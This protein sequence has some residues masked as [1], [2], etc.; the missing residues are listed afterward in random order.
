MQDT[1]SLP[2]GVGTRSFKSEGIRDKQ[3]RSCFGGCAASVQDEGYLPHIVFICLATSDEYA[4]GQ[5]GEICA[6]SFDA[7]C[8]LDGSVCTRGLLQEDNRRC[9]ESFTRCGGGSP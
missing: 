4:N 6:H 3:R 7:E 1:R 8:R 5:F 2:I 9:D